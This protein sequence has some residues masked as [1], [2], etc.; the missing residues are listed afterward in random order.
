MPDGRRPMY[1]GVWNTEAPPKV[2]VFTWRLAQEGLATQENRKQ[3]KLC[4]TTIY[5]ICGMEDEMGFHAVL[6]CT[7]V[8]ALRLEMRAH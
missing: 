8:F 5:Q 4:D 6:R 2:R 3:R 1:R 7:K